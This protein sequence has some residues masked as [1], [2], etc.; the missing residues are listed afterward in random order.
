MSY[1]PQ[2]PSDGGSS[3]PPAPAAPAPGYGQPGDAQP[4]YGQPSYGQ[5]GYGQPTL[6]T[7]APPLPAPGAVPHVY[8]SAAPA[9]PSPPT[10]RGTVWKVLGVLAVLAGLVG[11]GVLLLLSG[12]S[13]EEAVKKLARAPVGCTTT[14]EFTDTGT[15]VL[16]VERRG[17]MDEVDGD[18]DN[19]GRSYERADDDPPRVDLVLTDGDGAEVSLQSTDGPSYAAGGYIGNAVSSVR[20]EET[21]SYLLTVS[22][23]EDDF[24]IAVGSDQPD[25]NS[26][27]LLIGG[28]AVMVA[29]IVLGAVL[30]LMGRGRGR[31]STPPVAGATTVGQWPQQPT[32]PGYQPAGPG[33][34]AAQWPQQPTVPGYQPPAPLQPPTS[35]PAHG[36]VP[37]PNSPT[38]GWGAPPQ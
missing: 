13:E 16:Y 21:G 28:V 18:C 8:A 12:A 36:T 34:G 3:A 35:P 26:G 32:V 38:Q 22:S 20:I 15:F 37:P 25:G 11:G 30:L 5:P 31:N 14:L 10:R 9:P 1:Q 33:Y 23:S 6:P 24:A 2:P 4:S 29:G 27:V 7:S 17:T 19:D